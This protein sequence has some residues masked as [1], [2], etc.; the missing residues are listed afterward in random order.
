M[1][2][3]FLIL[4]RTLSWFCFEI[5]EGMHARAA[6]ASRTLDGSK[7]WI[8]ACCAA[9]PHRFQRE[10]STLTDASADLEQKTKALEEFEA[11]LRREKENAAEL[12]TQVMFTEEITRVRRISRK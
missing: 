5:H 7:C 4:V 11:V 1:A 8:A 9:Y 2:F 6:S 10:L 12:G 3:V